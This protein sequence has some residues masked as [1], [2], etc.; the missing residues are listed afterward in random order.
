MAPRRVHGR[1]MTC[2]FLVA[3]LSWLVAGSAFGALELGNAILV[4]AD[5]VAIDVPGYSVPSFVHWNEDGLKDL[6][7]GEGSGSYDARVRV[8][9]NVGAEH[10]PQFGGFFHAQSDGADLMLTGSGCLGL[11]P[12][13][14]YWDADDRKDLLVGTALGNVRIY[15]NVGTNDEPTF[16]GG[17]LLRVGLPGLKASIDVGSRATP[18]VVDY[19]DDGRRDLVVGAMDGRV[20][21]FINEGADTSPDF[22]AM[23][24]ATGSAGT[25]YVPT[26]RS[27]PIVVDLD[28]DGR[29]DLLVGNTNGQLLFYV[30]EG[31][32]AAPLFSGFEYVESSGVPI[33]LP[34]FARSRP[35]L[36]DWPDGAPHDVL[37]G[38]SDGRVRL[39][40][41]MSCPA[42][43]DGSGDVGFGDVLRVI[44]V[45][46]VCAPGCTRDL[47]GN[48]TVDFADLLVVIGSWGPC[49]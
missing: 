31:T 22:H 19:D 18:H 25:L 38:A 20:F 29:K 13:V 16:D 49:P 40:R 8:Y 11:F 46:G 1:R 4:E 24:F 5:G 39:Y 48:G 30:N 27:S 41:D 34:G 28:D 14:V 32:N 23:T 10:L 42:D 3:S 21:L 45:W 12:R 9:L 26:G 47:N 37:I 43:L 35:F 44:E 33:D 36:G 7:V 2:P 6:V 15:L 17:A